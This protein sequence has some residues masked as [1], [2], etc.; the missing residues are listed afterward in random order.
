M[1]YLFLVYILFIHSMF[2]QIGGLP[3]NIKNQIRNSGITDE[4]IKEIINDN[5][6]GLEMPSMFDGSSTNTSS[7]N[8]ELQKKDVQ[9]DINDLNSSTSSVELSQELIEENE[10]IIDE[11]VQKLDDENEDTIVENDLPLSSIDDLTFFGYNIFN[12]DPKLFDLSNNPNVDPNYI[13]GPGDEI[14][15]MLW[16]QTEI[17]KS[18]IVSLEGYL[19]IE[20]VGQVFVNGLTMDKLELKLF[21]L[22]K[23][24]YSSLG[25]PSESNASTFFDLSLGSLAVRPM[26]VFVLGDVIQPGA[27]SL[28]PSTTLFSSLFYFKGPSKSGSLREIQL[29]RNGK[30]IKK[31]DFYDYLLQGKKLNDSKLQRDDIIFVPSRGKT[32]AVKGE[33]NR[34]AIFEL[35]G[36]EDLKSILEMAGGLKS[37]SYTKRAQIKRITP[38]SDRN[39]TRMDRSILDI[40]LNE[41]LSINKKEKS[42]KLFDG[43]TLEI[44]KISNFVSNSVSILGAVNRPG[45]YQFFDGMNI[46]DL[47]NLADG[48]SNDAFTQ[49]IDIIRKVSYLEDYQISIDLNKAIRN[50]VIHNISLQPNDVITV[51]SLTEMIDVGSV[52]IEGHVFK[53]GIKPFYGGMTA[54]D[55]IF[56]GGGFKN[57]NHLKNTYKKRVDLF[58]FNNKSAFNELISFN[59]DSLLLEKGKFDID[60]KVDDRLVVYSIKDI[61]GDSALTVT[62]EGQVKFPGIYEL[63]ENMSV[64]ELFFMAGGFK[65][66]A[67][68]RTVLKNRFDIIRTFKSAERKKVISFNLDDVLSGEFE[69]SEIILEPNDLIRVYS[70]SLVDLSNTIRI[71]GSIRSP[72]QYDLKEYMDLGDLILESGGVDTNIYGFRAEISRLEPKNQKENQ[73]AKLHIFDFINDKSI[74]NNKNILN[75]NMNFELRSDDLVILR[76][77][78]LYSKQEKVEI[79]GFVYYPG[80]YV[81]TNSEERVSDII[82]RAGGLRPEG[83]ALA[84][85]LQRNGEIIRIN[86]EKI[87]KSPNS[88]F[89]FNVLPQDIITINSKPNLVV[90]SGEIYTPG[91][92]QFFRGNRLRDYI[93]LA[94]GLTRDASKYSSFITYPNGETKKI[95]FLK[96]SP[97]VVDGSVITIG[98]KDEVIPFDLT[99][100]V[101]NITDLYSQ[102]V[103]VYLLLSLSRQ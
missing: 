32:V 97:K 20:N 7:K 68:F 29:I 10:K 47:F 50:N 16:G 12:N 65:D 56:L 94:G 87:I 98:R 39:E 4:Q 64:N 91:N 57:K 100:Y 101:S 103:Q 48:V 96:I 51:Y 74:F 22:L 31:I 72:G 83:Y 78:P 30:V 80:E 35:R 76:P 11:N 14:K 95:K 75:N 46:V 23:K 77:S 59:L 88:S 99:Q 66:I 1:R 40:N 55:L 60:L 89:N 67:F 27:Y 81:I 82:N 69:N 19:F 52:S 49:K 33:I 41:I 43:D 61:I 34:P 86:F 28:N 42:I 18:Y 17:N 73:Y 5:S 37:T 70:K 44:F 53:P 21:K 90:I 8:V 63:T 36:S 54:F 2:G 13:V 79:D 71:E 6:S 9:N 102:F 62:L 25:S 38:A 26:R 58:R 45:A 93:E 85:T 84:S 92:Y 3:S 24:V 15:V